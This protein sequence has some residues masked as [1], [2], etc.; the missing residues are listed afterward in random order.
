MKLLDSHSSCLVKLSM[1][2]SDRPRSRQLWSLRF[3]SWWTRWARQ[4]LNE[5]C[6]VWFDW[7]SVKVLQS[8]SD[9]CKFNRRFSASS[10]VHIYVA[11]CRH[12]SPLS[13]SSHGFPTLKVRDSRK[14]P[15]S[16]PPPWHP[17]SVAHG[18]FWAS[19]PWASFFGLPQGSAGTLLNF[20][21]PENGVLQNPKNANYMLH[22][23]SD[24]RML[25]NSMIFN[26]IHMHMNI[27]F[28]DLFC[29]VKPSLVL[30]AF[31]TGA[32]FSVWLPP[33]HE[34]PILLQFSVALTSAKQLRVLDKKSM[35]FDVFSLYQYHPV[36]CGKSIFF[37]PELNV[38]D[39]WWL[40]LKQF[41]IIWF[42]C[43]MCFIAESSRSSLPSAFSCGVMLLVAL[44][45][46][47]PS[48]KLPSGRGKTGI[49]RR[50]SGMLG[51]L[52]AL[53]K[54]QEEDEAWQP[55]NGWNREEKIWPLWLVLKDDFT[56][57]RG[58]RVYQI[59]GFD[60]SFHFV[61]PFFH[62]RT[63]G[64]DW[65]IMNHQT[66]GCFTV[67][68][69]HGCL[70]IVR[71]L[72]IN[73]YRYSLLGMN[74]CLPPIWMFTR[75]TWFWPIPRYPPCFSYKEQ[76]EKYGSPAKVYA[77]FRQIHIGL[78]KHWGMA[79]GYTIALMN[80]L[81]FCS[82]HKTWVCPNKNGLKLPDVTE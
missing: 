8:D 42:W 63:E 10:S 43:F 55:V 59:I 66:S 14:R 19:G 23:F 73:T 35:M 64:L 82:L 5:A 39:V 27:F 56:S 12:M 13:W 81:M 77:V 54:E 3:M 11:I 6:L 50:A 68:F 51:G 2:L 69:H 38:W 25:C 28:L 31:A 48:V 34:H 79:S 33:V 52:D 40:L 4:L 16:P 37:V 24:L 18:C 65:T 9:F 72:W 78:I 32:S 75:A 62:V 17:A 41:A 15:R 58:I 20:R 22:R 76:W 7:L 70:K 67:W 45:A 26:D 74:I 44:S 46:A 53:K 60:Q 1:K 49:A 61:A 29:F 80:H 57:D 71:W 21:C 30:P 36:P 47:R